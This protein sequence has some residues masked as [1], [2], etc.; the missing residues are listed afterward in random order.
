MKQSTHAQARTEEE[1]LLLLK[2]AL[3]PSASVRALDEGGPG[4]AVEVRLAGGEAVVLTLAP[5]A[6]SGADPGPDPHRVWV[7]PRATRGLHERLR[8]RR[9][10][11]VDLRGAV[12]LSL[13]TLLVDRT[14]VKPPR[15][16]KAAPPPADPFSDRGSLVLRTLLEAGGRAWRVRELAEAAGVGP[17]TVTRVVRELRR[18]HVVD[19]PR[20]GRAA[21]V[22]LTDARALFTL[23]TGAYDWMRNRAVAFHAPLGDPERFLRRADRFFGERRWALTLHAGA[24]RVAPH[25]AWERVHVYVDVDSAGEL[26]ELGER[27]GWPAADDGRLV[28]MKPYYR[29]SVWHGLQTARDLPVVSTLQLALDL[30]S[31][32]LRG[33]EQAE[34]LLDA[35]HLFP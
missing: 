17:A 11:F 18:Y 32:P 13:P 1:A 22:R 14:G 27:E 24:A 8:K 34:H 26:L 31:Y 15:R 5:W 30:W 10:S 6:R 19:A 21:A 33:R 3:Q 12:H 25:A 28:L 4:H 23:W 29:D 20:A 7:L 9:E 16:P 2:E 35:A